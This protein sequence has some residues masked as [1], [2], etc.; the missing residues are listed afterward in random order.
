LAGQ[1][2]REWPVWQVCA[3]LVSATLLGFA[4]AEGLAP[5]RIAASAAIVL[6]AI[7]IDLVF[8]HYMELRWQHRPLRQALT[9]WLAAVTAILL[10]GYWAG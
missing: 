3:V 4:L 5:A 7:K 6:A 8:A 9:L 1:A 2:T 10:A